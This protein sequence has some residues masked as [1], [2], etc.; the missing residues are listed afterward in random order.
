MIK[1]RSYGSF[2]ETKSFHLN[3]YKN[4][5]VLISTACNSNDIPYH[6]LENNFYISFHCSVLRDASL[7]TR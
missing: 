4:I 1:R 3:I 6:T 2:T 5:H 7:D